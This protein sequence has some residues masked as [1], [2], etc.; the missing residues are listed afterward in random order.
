[1][2]G[3]LTSSSCAS[4]SLKLDHAIQLVGYNADASTP[5]WIVRNSWGS[6]WGEDGYIYLEMDTK[7]LWSC[8]Q[9]RH[10]LP[11]SCVITPPPTQRGN[12]QSKS[13]YHSGRRPGFLGTPINEWVLST[14]TNHAAST[15]R[16]RLILI[17]LL[18]GSAQK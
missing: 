15:V 14:T 12:D 2:G 17:L 6:S 11:L 7:H 1:M 9:G 13:S 4:S 3:V 16:C 5:Y 10:G 8:G 18:A